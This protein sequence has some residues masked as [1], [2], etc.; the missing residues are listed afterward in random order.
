[1]I[2]IRTQEQALW[3][4]QQINN[5][6]KSNGNTLLSSSQATEKIKSPQ[7]LS[8]IETRY[9]KERKHGVFVSGNIIQENMATLFIIGN[10][11]DLAHGLST[12]Y[13]DLKQYISTKD[14]EVYKQIN[15]Q[16]FVGNQDLWSSFECNVGTKDD[17]FEQGLMDIIQTTQDMADSMPAGGD[18]MEGDVLIQKEN[19]DYA[20]E[21]AISQSLNSEYEKF[22]FG[23]LYDVFLSDLKEL[24]K[25]ADIVSLSK[26]RNAI[27]EALITVS[28]N[29]KFITFN[30][31]HT[32][33]HIYD[34]NKED[35]M[36]L[37]GE[38]GHTEILFGNQEEKITELE[39]ENFIE[40]DKEYEKYQKECDDYNA[41]SP[42]ERKN[43]NYYPET[44]HDYLSYPNL[45]GIDCSEYV[46]QY[47]E[48]KKQW[49]KHLEVAKFEEFIKPCDFDNI[50]ILGHSLGEVDIEYFRKLDTRFP[51]AK[52]T[53]SVH[54]VDGKTSITRT[55]IKTFFPQK[56]VNFFNL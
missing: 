26:N 19:N 48:C 33:E 39:S 43:C 14:A 40:T 54:E 25:A 3:L 34:V 4:I 28:T 5:S 17:Y 15:E 36:Y 6:D 55:N 8:C 51:N 37:H 23:D 29:P 49:I 1:M 22:H 35:I 11:F 12:S 24:L 47:N 50:V 13:F 44:L 56:K 20:I 38:L 46:R 53:V 41:L 52:W 2:E 30:Y 42:E 10:G 9:K 45:K 7:Y 21:Q 18:P 32:L 16:L 31:T 27:I